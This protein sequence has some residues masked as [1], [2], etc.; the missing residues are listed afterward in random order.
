MKKWLIAVVLVLVLA[1][2]AGCVL[3]CIRFVKLYSGEKE[4]ASS[5][6]DGEVAQYVQAHWSM[7][8]VNYDG[9]TQALTLRK[10]TNIEY[11]K[12]CLYGASVYS[13][14]LA[15]E[16]YL[17]E[18]RS[19]GMDVLSR[20]DCPSL[21]VK[22]LYESSDGKTIFTVASDGTVWTCWEE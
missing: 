10:T 2:L 9:I 1:L 21:S 14:D 19:I 16:N 6:Q 17:S 11:D 13:G 3:L 20:F 4:P 22:L 15:P 18:I 5:P 8:S 12:A 7:F